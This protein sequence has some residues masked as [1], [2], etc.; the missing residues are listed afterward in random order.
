MELAYGEQYQRSRMAGDI[1][2]GSRRA[3]ASSGLVRALT[4]TRRTAFG[5]PRI[6]CAIC[7]GVTIAPSSA[8]PEFKMPPMRSFLPEIS[9]VSPTASLASAASLPEASW[10]RRPVVIILRPFALHLPPAVDA[11]CA[12]REG[13]LAIVQGLIEIGS[14]Q[15]GLEGL[16]ILAERFD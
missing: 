12:G 5:F 6:C 14:D 13:F 1:L 2:L 10:L 15:L 16:A 7:R 11:A 8:P 4:I 9:M 3:K